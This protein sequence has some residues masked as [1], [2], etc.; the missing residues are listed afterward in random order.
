MAVLLL[1]WKLALGS[2]ASYINALVI[3]KGDIANIPPAAPKDFAVIQ[4]NG[5][6]NL[7]W[8]DVAFNED[9]YEV[10]RA[11]DTNGTFY[12]T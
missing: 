1:I 5:I 6:A 11:T 7:S 9:G 3:T 4:E 10:Y 2:T 8:R 12:F